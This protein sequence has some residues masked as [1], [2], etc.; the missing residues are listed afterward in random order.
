M[1]H[2][3]AVLV[4]FPGPF[5]SGVFDLT[6]RGKSA[7]MPGNIHVMFCASRQSVE[8]DGVGKIRSRSPLSPARFQPRFPTPVCHLAFPTVRFQGV[9]EVCTCRIIS[10]PL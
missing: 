5:A 4:E 3:S 1:A 6:D 8:W 10:M 7:R 2:I 9:N